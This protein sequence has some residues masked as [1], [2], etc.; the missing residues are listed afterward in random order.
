MSTTPG[1][2][3][4]T[5]K[6]PWMLKPFEIDLLRQGLKAA[7]GSFCGLSAYQ[8]RSA[9][10]IETGGPAVSRASS[11]ANRVPIRMAATTAVH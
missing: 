7:C 5:S 1:R 9:A 8:A 11:H 10:R 3:L 4:A 6:S 2:K